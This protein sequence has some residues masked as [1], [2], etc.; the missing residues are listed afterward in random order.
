MNTS[1]NKT[2]ELAPGKYFIGDVSY[3]L[4]DKYYESVKENLYGCNKGQLFCG[5]QIVTLM[6]TVWSKK[7]IWLGSNKEIYSVDSGVLGICSVDMGEDMGVGSVHEF[8]DKVFVDMNANGVLKVC[9]GKD[10]III[11]TTKECVSD[12]EDSGYDS[13]G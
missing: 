2:Y 1:Q 10:S 9:S 11:D 6:Q 8:R 5:G 4:T 13:W 3:F 12:Y 7:G